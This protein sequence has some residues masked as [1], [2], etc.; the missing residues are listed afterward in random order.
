[1]DEDERIIVPA[2]LV[3]SGVNG[4][5]AREEHQDQKNHLGPCNCP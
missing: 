5:Q 2:H 3:S 1:M 4:E